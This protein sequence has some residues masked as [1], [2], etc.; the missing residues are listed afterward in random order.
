MA[1]AGSTRPRGL[2]APERRWAGQARGRGGAGSLLDSEEWGF[3]GK[4]AS[5][6]AP[7]HAGERP[8]GSA[9]MIDLMSSVPNPISAGRYLFAPGSAVTLESRAVQNRWRLVVSDQ[10]PGPKAGA[11]LGLA[12]CR[13][14][15][16]LHG[17]RIHAEN[18]VG[19]AGFRVVVDRPVNQAV[20]LGLMG[21]WT[22]FDPV[23]IRGRT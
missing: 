17:G 1:P 13:S 23:H 8:E 19:A 14:I 9:A 18:C 2:Q 7:A 6:C 22:V 20:S 3:R 21:G 4:F 10:G 15:A 5:P 16:T 12:I 11:G